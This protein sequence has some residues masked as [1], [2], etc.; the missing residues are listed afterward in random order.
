MRER[1]ISRV[2]GHL[3]I[4][5]IYLDGTEEL[6]WDE[7]NVI[8]SGMAVNLA[9]LL[10]DAGYNTISSPSILDYQ[11]A[12][13]QVGVSGVSTYG[14]STYT[15]GS[16]IPASYLSANGGLVYNSHSQLANGTTLTSQPFLAIAAA[17]IFKASPTSVR[18]HLIIPADELNGLSSSNIPINEIGLFTRNTR[19]QSPEE[20]ILVAY[21]YFSNIVKTSDF[22]LFFRW[23]INF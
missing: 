15:L 12:Y 5:K 22:A 4:F 14:T 6:I 7:N 20:S 8:T 13:W 19:K 11:I 1:S 2:S 18:Y 9:Y 10:G 21:K 3:Q 17:N 16:A 23:V